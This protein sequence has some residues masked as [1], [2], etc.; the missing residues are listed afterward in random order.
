MAR[1]AAQNLR[2]GRDGNDHG[3]QRQRH[4][5]GLGLTA[6]A[7]I[8]ARKTSQDEDVCLP[9]CCDSYWMSGL[10]PSPGEFEGLDCSLASRP[11]E[12]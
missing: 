12:D 1:V 3:L 5:S 6:T 10:A 8:T 2:G 7:T 4:F 11:I 9:K